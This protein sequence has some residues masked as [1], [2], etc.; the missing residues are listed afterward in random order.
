MIFLADMTS[1]RLAKASQRLAHAY[2]RLAHAS[3]RQAHAPQR[4]AHASQRLLRPPRGWLRCWGVCT[5]V[6]TY[7]FPLCSTGLRPPSGPKP[8]KPVA[9]RQE[10]DIGTLA[11]LWYFII[12]AVM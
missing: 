2:E 6:Q 7:R 3:Q 4:L 11:L 9:P 12:V 8:K 5:G 10:M 1:G